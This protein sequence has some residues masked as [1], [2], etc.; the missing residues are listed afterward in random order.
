MKIGKI[1]ESVLKR[2]IIKEIKYKRKDIKK[3][4]A[5]GNDAMVMSVGGEDMAVATASYSGELLMAG[6]RCLAGAL[7]SLAAK[8]GEPMA[9]TVSVMLPQ[10][11]KESH[12]RNLMT[13]L[14]R[15]AGQFGAQI[16]GGHTETCQC[17]NTSVVTINAIGRL[18]GMYKDERGKIAPGMD[19]VMI[20]E[21][22]LDGTSVL[23][24]ENRENLSNR[25][26]VS[27]IDS[28]VKLYEKIFT[29]NEAA[30]AI[31]HGGKAMHDASKGGIFGALWE[32][33]EYCRCG[34]NINLK[35]IPIRQETIE[36]CEHFDLN[37][38]FL[39]SLGGLLIVTADGEG[40]VS[41]MSAVGK[42][43]A[44]IGKLTEGRDKVII[45]NDEKRFLEPPKAGKNEYIL[46]RK[47][48]N[49]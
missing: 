42:T 3:G 40:L 29:V 30:V 48:D 13:E 14:D 47:E 49:D 4:A 19:I 15:V 43:A 28:A 16:G 21:A 26:T 45:N 44:V 9:V 2:T 8:G 1:S 17:L 18:N 36:I 27:Y 38:Y 41:Q 20:G 31:Q 10:S 37:P 22:A 5:V 32:L 11:E 25:F 39:S 23:A 46:E 34:M 6:R 7:N 24:C 33:G 12:L 35:A